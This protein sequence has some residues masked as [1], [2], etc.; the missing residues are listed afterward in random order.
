MLFLSHLSKSK[1]RRTAT[2]FFQS[3]TRKLGHQHSLNGYPLNSTTA[4][5]SSSA[6]GAQQA[7]SANPPTTT[8]VSNF[9]HPSTA[10]GSSSNNN[11][12]NNNPK[13]YMD[14]N[15]PKAFHDLHIKSHNNVTLVPSN[16]NRNRYT[17]Y[18]II[19]KFVCLFLQSESCMLTL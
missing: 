14:K 19:K 7:S 5:A 6:A 17:Y 13:M 12:N 16:H 3:A 4:A 1:I 8:T 2:A 15:R 18:I 10:N 11:N 9:N